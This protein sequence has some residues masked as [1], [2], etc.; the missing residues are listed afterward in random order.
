MLVS[1]EVGEV[2]LVRSEVG[3]VRLGFTILVSLKNGCST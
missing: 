3:E 2:R 1:T